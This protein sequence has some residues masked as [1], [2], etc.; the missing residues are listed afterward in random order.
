[1]PEGLQLGEDLDR[2]GTPGSGHHPGKG[3]IVEML[4][5]TGPLQPGGHIVPMMLIP[6][7]ENPLLDPFLG[8]LL[9]LLFLRQYFGQPGFI[10]WR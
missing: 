7:M 1:M 10:G 4:E 3:P 8:L 9:V 2:P 6:E 5:P